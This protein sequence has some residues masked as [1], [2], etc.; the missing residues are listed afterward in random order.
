M[1]RGSIMNNSKI[2]MNHTKAYRSPSIEV[3]R[4][5]VIDIID[6][7]INGYRAIHVNDISDWSLDM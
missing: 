1:K 7:S 6:A 5:D 3:I 4:L 2:Q